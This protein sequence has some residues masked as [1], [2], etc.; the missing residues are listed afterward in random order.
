VNESFI[1]KREEIVD[2]FWEIFMAHEWQKV[3]E[4]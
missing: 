1:F 4:E 3:S 2:P